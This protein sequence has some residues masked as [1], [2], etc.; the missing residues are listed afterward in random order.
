MPQTATDQA[1]QL[2]TVDD[3]EPIPM[4]LFVGQLPKTMTDDELKAQFEPYGAVLSAEIVRVRATGESRQCGFVVVES[5]VVADKAIA[6]M[7][8]KK[9]IPPVRVMKCSRF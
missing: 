1:Q 6:E 2:N 8:A 3:D 9:I 5:K 4:R 7:N